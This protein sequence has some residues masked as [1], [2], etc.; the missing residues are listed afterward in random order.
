MNRLPLLDT[1]E[2][3]ELIG[4]KSQTL[5]YW[6]HIG[7]Q[8]PRSFRMGGRRVYYRRE[9]V[10]AWVNEQYNAENPSASATV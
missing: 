1:D 7:N 6:R 9:D 5:R 3:A 10:E 4:I 2:V 8:G